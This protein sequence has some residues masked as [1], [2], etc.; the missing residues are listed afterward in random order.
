MVRNLSEPTEEV[1]AGTSHAQPL[2]AAG[3]Q[4]GQQVKRHRTLSKLRGLLDR[5]ERRF[6]T[7]SAV[8]RAD[9]FTPSSPASGEASS[10]AKKGEERADDDRQGVWATGC[11]EI[12]LR[13][14]RD[15]S[16][17]RAHKEPHE[18]GKITRPDDPRGMLD[19]GGLHEITG[20]TYRDQPAACA[21]ALALLAR[22]TRATGHGG[23]SS[24]LWCQAARDA[25]EFG[26]LYAR[27]VD[28]FAP[29]GEWA[30]RLVCVETTKVRDV[31]WAV[32]EGARTSGLAAVIAHVGQVSFT[33][34]RRLALAAATG[35]TAVLLLRPHDDHVAT[36][37]A[38]RW[39]IASARSMPSTLFKA[40][41]G[42]P[43]WSVALERSRGGRPGRWLVEW[44]HET[45]RL[46]LVEEF[47]SRH[48]GVV[49]PS[50]SE[51]DSPRI[52]RLAA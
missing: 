28:G 25:N 10:L 17:A 26:R 15:Q 20:A 41:P 4:V 33:E 22:L 46:D 6:A 50:Q 13:L 24:L 27:G 44:T 8:A 52:I 2:S 51:T 34:S 21:F 30:S 3:P 32:E 7:P 31:L 49:S 42:N 47:S 36:A 43:C 1:S 40:A 14:P 38:T 11:P 37:A 29:G 18:R 48:A 12:D 39:R 5:T 23:L 9:I 19:R 45:H 16:H 35:G